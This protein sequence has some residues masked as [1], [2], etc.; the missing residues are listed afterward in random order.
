MMQMI[1][2]IRRNHKEFCLR[3]FILSKIFKFMVKVEIPIDWNA[4]TGNFLFVL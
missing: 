2:K 3:T 1:S 4:N